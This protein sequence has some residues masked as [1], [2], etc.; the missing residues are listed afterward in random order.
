MATATFKCPNC[1]GGLKFDPDVQKST[2]EFCLSEFT[3]QEL[4]EISAAI[5][6]KAAAAQQEE[7][8]QQTQQEKTAQSAVEVS[9]SETGKSEDPLAHMVGYVCDSC[10]AEVVTEDTTSATFCY[11]CHN[12]VLVTSRLSG[13]FKP[14]K[15]V[16]FQYD[17][18]KAIQ[19]FLGWAKTKKFV[20]QSFY[21][22]SQLEKIT[23]LYLPYWMADYQANVDYAGVGT[24][25]RVWISGN[26]EHTE[27][28]DYRIERQG[29]IEVDHIH[30][31]AMKKIDKG[32][33]DSITPFDEKQAID[34]NMS[35]LNGFFAE[36]YDIS[37]DEVRP[38]IEN[39]TRSYVSMLLQESIGAYSQIK[40]ERNSMDLS[41]KSWQY[42]LFP[43]WILTYQYQG[44]TY[45]Y[46]INGQT[47]TAHGEL[48]VD[49][50]KL[51]LTTALI[52]AVILA[53]TI[54]GGWLLW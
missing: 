9:S 42:T 2:C 32:L 7:Q 50:K 12:P 36:K 22:T 53:L 8:A 5:E 11:Y 39:R 6:M 54:L 25:R 17:R 41:L 49:K 24:N 1:G 31:L 28:K 10:G 14:D 26:M 40:E 18:E 52:A 48:P 34:F 21:S 13:V 19:K 4:A 46:A 37:K 47:G 20:P 44:K 43:T 16:P 51:S 35:Y 30:E 29:T 15:I 23:G 27:Y 3:N 38:V 45:I 33:I